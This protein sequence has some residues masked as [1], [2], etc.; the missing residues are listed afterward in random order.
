MTNSKTDIYYFSKVDEKKT[1]I[2]ECE[3]IKTFMYGR[4]NFFLLYKKG[5][6]FICT[7]DKKDDLCSIWSRLKKGRTPNEIL[8]IFRKEFDRNS[9]NKDL[10]ENFLKQPKKYVIK[11]KRL[12]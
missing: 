4:V 12:K 5:W 11:K 6:F 1:C 3:I 9:I 10:I 8:S 7:N 2:K